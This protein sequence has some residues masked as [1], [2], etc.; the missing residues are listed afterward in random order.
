MSART[1]KSTSPSQMPTLSVGSDEEAPK[2]SLENNVV[3]EPVAAQ[4]PA[5]QEPEAKRQ[6]KHRFRPGTVAIRE[7]RKEQKSTDLIFPKTPFQRLVREIAQD[8]NK[9]ELLWSGDAIEA[10]QVASEAFL[11]ELFQDSNDLAIFRDCETIEPRDMQ[12]ALKLRRDP[13]MGRRL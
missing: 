13:A 8:M 1:T 12:M 7:I 3:V 11:I 4:E 6:K 5:A 9:E 10:L 2:T